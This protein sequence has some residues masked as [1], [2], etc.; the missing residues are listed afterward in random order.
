MQTINGTLACCACA[1]PD[2]LSL[3]ACYIKYSVV[4]TL[5]ELVKNFTQ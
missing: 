2:P 4:I 1:P 3:P 5:I